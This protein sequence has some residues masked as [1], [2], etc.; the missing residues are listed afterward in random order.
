MNHDEEEIT[1]TGGRLN[2]QHF[3]FHLTHKKSPTMSVSRGFL[4][5][6]GYNGTERKEI[7]VV[8]AGVRERETE[9]GDQPKKSTTSCMRLWFDGFLYGYSSSVDDEWTWIRLYCIPFPG[10]WVTLQ[11]SADEV[12]AWIS[13]I[14]FRPFQLIR[15]IIVVRM[16]L[17]QFY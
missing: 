1:D 4:W 3:E 14:P 17:I 9:T 13:L 8:R 16:G 6:L 12:I 7:G 10:D 5:L 2:S 15:V 11:S